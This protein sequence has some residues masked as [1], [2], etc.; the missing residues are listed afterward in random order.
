MKDKYKMTMD[1][2]MRAEKQ[3]L[4][5]NGIGRFFYDDDEEKRV[6]KLRVLF[7]D[8]TFNKLYN[9]MSNMYK[10]KLP[11]NMSERT[12]ERAFIEYG[13]V[14]V[15]RNKEGEWNLPARPNGKFTKYGDPTEVSTYAFDGTSE[16]IKVKYKYQLSDKE[17]LDKKRDGGV[18]GRDNFRGYPYLQYIEEYA[19]ILTDIRMTLYNATQKLKSPFMFGVA[20]QKTSKELKDKLNR[21]MK[22][23][24]IWIDIKPLIAGGGKVSDVIEQFDLK[25]DPSSIDA[26]KGSIEF[27]FNE[28]LSTIGIDTDPSPDK[29]QYVSNNEI[30]SNNEY[31]YFTDNLRFKS[32][33]ELCENV[34]DL[35]GIE[36][37][38]EK[39]EDEEMKAIIEET[40]NSLMGNGKKDNIEKG[41]K[42]DEKGKV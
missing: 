5:I 14:C 17:K 29:S 36:I 15:F 32:R 3:Q 8:N 6:S 24:N 34:K 42:Q 16:V 31:L 11:D 19:N 2:Y 1:E 33:Q 22:G 27:Y 7:F 18:Y 30:G 13:G 10:W 21:V 35:L 9:L 23:E 20:D 4:P 28:F 38:V 41:G 39:N 37:S 40:K 26:I 25:G 12:M